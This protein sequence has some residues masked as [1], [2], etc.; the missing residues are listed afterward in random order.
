M[1]Q[2]VIVLLPKKPNSET[3]ADYRPITLLNIDYKILTKYLNQVYFP[4]FLKANISPEQLCAVPGRNIHNG[5]IFIRDVIEY[6]RDKEKSG[7]LM[8][9][10]QRKAFDLVDRK[11]MFQVL[12]KMNFNN[13]VLAVIKTLYHQTSTSVQVNGHY[14]WRY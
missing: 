11:F 6:C 4:E 2:A 3:P 12:E 7:I 5:T 9:L 14:F 1:T 10:D 13:D 8:S